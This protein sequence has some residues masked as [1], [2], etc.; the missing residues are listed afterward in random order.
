[1][2]RFSLLSLEGQYQLLKEEPLIFGGGA[3]VG[4]NCKLEVG[5]NREPWAGEKKKD[6]EHL[7]LRYIR[8]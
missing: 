5:E 2:D 6:L 3:N 4:T 1:M 8:K 7:G